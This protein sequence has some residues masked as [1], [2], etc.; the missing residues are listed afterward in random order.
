[1]SDTTTANTSDHKPLSTHQFPNGLPET[2]LRAIRGMVGGFMLRK[3]DIYE[4]GQGYVPEEGPVIF[5]SNHIGWL[6]GPLMFIKAP[7]DVHTLVKEEEFEGKKAHLLRTISQIKVARAHVDTGA[8]RTATAALSA[9]QAVGIFP[10]GTR[11]NGEFDSIKNGIGYL[12]L[13]TGAPIV[14]MAIFG[15][16]EKGADASSRPP[17]GARI[18]VVYGRPFRMNAIEWPRTADQIGAAVSEIHDNLRAHLEYSK[19]AVKRELPGDLPA[20]Q[21][22]EPAQVTTHG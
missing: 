5:A 17:K 3:W 4:R 15:T 9:G 2:G 10:E 19:Q 18:D 8:M 12:A 14:P 20:R 6:D 16:R 22:A 1:M 21:P 13:V 11:G 7:R